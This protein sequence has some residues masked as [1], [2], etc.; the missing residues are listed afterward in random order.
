MLC[1]HIESCTKQVRARMRA[2]ARRAHRGACSMNNDPP[3]SPLMVMPY[4]SSSQ[5]YH[6]L[7]IQRC[8]PPKSPNPL[9][10][11]SRSNQRMSQN[12]QIAITGNQNNWRN[13]ATITVPEVGVPESNTSDNG[14]PTSRLNVQV[15]TIKW[16]LTFQNRM[17]N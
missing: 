15:N 14:T 7:I 9:I 4:N 17:Q 8:R 11:L 2:R 10:R 6:I 1:T 3:P 5:H 13:T 12:S 16:S